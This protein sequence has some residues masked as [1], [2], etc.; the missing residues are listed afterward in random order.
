MIIERQ[1]FDSN[2]PKSFIC[3]NTVRLDLLIVYL[4]FRFNKEKVITRFVLLKKCWLAQSSLKCAVAKR[5]LPVKIVPLS[6]P[7]HKQATVF[8]CL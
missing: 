6:S 7:A 5:I 3:V 4:N 2:I 8:T 1:V